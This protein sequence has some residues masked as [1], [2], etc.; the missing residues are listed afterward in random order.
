MIDSTGSMSSWIK[1]VK[2]KCKEK[3]TIDDNFIDSKTKDEEL[4]E[5]ENNLNTILT[6]I[7]NK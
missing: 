2:D 7:Y 5:I 4:T 6:N 1:G 3:I